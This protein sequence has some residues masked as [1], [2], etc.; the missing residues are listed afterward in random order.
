LLALKVS[1]RV[2]FWQ[3]IEEKMRLECNFNVYYRY[4]Q[5]FFADNT[6]LGH[7]IGK[8]FNLDLHFDDVF[9]THYEVMLGK[10]PE[11]KNAKHKNVNYYRGTYFI[12]NFHECNIETFTV[13]CHDMDLIRAFPNQIDRHRVVKWLNSIADLEHF[14]CTDEIDFT[15]SLSTAERIEFNEESY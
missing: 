12:V 10:I 13:P 1:L 7:S 3:E 2:V 6:K 5:K 11:Y 15:Y 8:I 9:D 4:Y 14:I